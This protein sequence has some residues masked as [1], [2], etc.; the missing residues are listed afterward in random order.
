MENSF[1]DVKLASRP[2]KQTKTCPDA[3]FFESSV[4]T[5]RS[6]RCSA[7]SATTQ[8]RGVRAPHLRLLHLRA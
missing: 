1:K 6:R 5:G 7:C 8:T 2:E 3:I 4:S